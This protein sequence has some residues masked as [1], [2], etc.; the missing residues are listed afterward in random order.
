[1]INGIRSNV[2]SEPYYETMKLAMN[3]IPELP[4]NISF[5]ES[6]KI[7]LKRYKK[8]QSNEGVKK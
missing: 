8:I 4:S 5:N 2:E 6:L 1:M 7:V 3:L